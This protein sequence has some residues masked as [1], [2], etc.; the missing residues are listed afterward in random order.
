M[1]LARWGLGVRDL[2]QGVLSYGGRLG[3]EDAGETANTQVSIHDYGNKTLV[4]EVRGLPTDPHKG[5][6]VGVIF[7]GTQGYAVM[8]SYNGGAVFDL[9]GKQV[10][11]YDEGGDH[12]ANFIKAVRSR[13]IE[14]LNGEVEEGHLS[15]ALCHLGNVSYRLGEVMPVDEV[16][17]RLESARTKDECLETFDRF[18]QHLTANQISLGSTNLQFG[19]LLKV[20]GKA[21]TFSGSQSDKANPMLTREYRKG[22]EVP[23][24]AQLA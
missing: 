23:T 17:K 19:A 1:D 24:A 5:A 9:D 3:Y 14:D 20:D 15:S 10:R 8:G 2:G 4:F 7:Y 21:E 13:K 22:F 18:K 16:Q 6:G 12:F 11:K